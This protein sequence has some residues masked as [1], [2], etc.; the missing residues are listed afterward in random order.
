M[1]VCVWDREKHTEKK[2]KYLNNLAEKL[3]K[4]KQDKKKKTKKIRDNKIVLNK[5]A[6][7]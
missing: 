2:I 5:I 7:W 4:V 6:V 1:P 3:R